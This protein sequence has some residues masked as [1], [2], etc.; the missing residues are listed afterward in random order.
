M[1]RQD[2]VDE[3]RDAQATDGKKSSNG[4]CGVKVGGL[5]GA[6]LAMGESRRPCLKLNSP[7]DFGPKGERS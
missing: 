3:H 6:E 4:R 1:N 5:S 7:K 2:S